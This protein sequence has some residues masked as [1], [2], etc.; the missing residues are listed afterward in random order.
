[1]TYPVPPNEIERLSALREI[2]LLDTAPE[3]HFDAVVNLSRRLFGVPIALVSLLDADRQWFKA[4]CGLDVSGTS[5]DVAFCAYTILSDE[6]LVVE[7]AANDARFQANPLVTGE[8]RIRFYAG[9]PL[10]LEPGLRI[11]TLCLIDTAP[12]SFSEE[13]RTALRELA[14][15]VISH[16]RLHRANG[17][18]RLEAQQR[19]VTQ[20]QL[21][22]NEAFLRSVLDSST[23]CIKVVELD[24]SLSFMN[25]HGLCA[26]EIESF[27]AIKGAQWAQLW[28]QETASRVR[29]AMAEAASGKTDRFEAFCPTAKGTPK[30]WDVSVSPVQKPD[31]QIVSLVSVSR[32]ITERTRSEVALREGEERLRLALDA[33]HLATWDWDMVTGKV[34][35]S[36]QHYTL[37]GYEVGEITPSYE[38]WAERV[39]PND[40]REAQERI[41]AAQDERQRYDHTFRF[42]HPSGHVVWCEAHGQ[43]TYDGTG[44]ATRMVG[45]LRDITEQKLAQDALKEAKAAAEQAN[46]A[47][48]E[49]LATMSHEIRTPLNGIMGLT[50]LLQDKDYGDPELKRRLEQLKVSSSALLTVV[51]DVLDFSKIEAGA[52]E[53]EPAPFWPR[54][55]TTS[56]ANMVRDLA[57][58]KGLTLVVD[59][60]AT[61]PSRVIGDEPRLRQV[62]LNLLNNAVKFTP[63]GTVHL[64]LEH[65]PDEAG[66]EKLR[67]TVKDTGIGIPRDKQS[68]LFERFR[69]VDGSHTRQYGGTGLGLAISKSLVEL[70]GGRIGLE[71]QEG[72]GTSVWFELVLPQAQ[73]Q[74]VELLADE[75]DAPDVPA[76]T[77]RV[78]LAEDVAIN[79]E[80]VKAMLEAAGH[81]VEVVS[82]GVEAVRAVQEHDFDLV[83][84]DVQMPEM[85]GLEATRRIRGMQGPK[86][87]VPIIALTANV[88]QDQIREFT[89]AGMSLHVGKP[90]RRD[91]L[92][93]AVQQCLENSQQDI[94]LVKWQGALAG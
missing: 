30:W 41:R 5:R 56:C 87:D 82:T 16:L 44:A 26:M 24:G 8:P 10:A 3:A 84:M 28:P 48:S 71:S 90:M 13:D 33:G 18:I 85:D 7:D 59:T 75:S 57:A 36:D 69:Q 23:D 11:G 22:R 47:K 73:G 27:D 63:A 1:M 45:V 62:L 86:S 42:L 66:G 6:L 68:R 38:V 77:G 60:G 40:L 17:T 37:L 81:R 89:A 43:F 50:E 46:E 78:L 53:L 76:R 93:G 32:D 74:A 20:R 15:V 34:V 64:V 54:A 72:K 9:A 31:G 94:A 65:E 19:L 80:I 67:F 29:E 52:V 12:R 61:P 49:F 51:N 88:F 70:M 21:L 58:K 35:W 2:Q 39:H 4:R 55:M 79:Q 92:L 91:E 25:A 83:L 14:E